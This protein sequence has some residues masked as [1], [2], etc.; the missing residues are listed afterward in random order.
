MGAKKELRFS[1]CVSAIA[2]VCVGA[3]N[4]IGWLKSYVFDHGQPLF[5]GRVAMMN[6]PRREVT[7]VDFRDL[8]CNFAWKVLHNH[9]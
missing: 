8:A 4:V 9:S 7:S 1:F 6:D 3:C 2:T 5:G